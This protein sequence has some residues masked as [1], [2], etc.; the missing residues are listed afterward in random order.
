MGRD[1]RVTGTAWIGCGKLALSRENM[2]L[3][4]KESLST[5]KQVSTSS[6]F[7]PVHSFPNSTITRRCRLSSFFIYNHAHT[8]FPSEWKVVFILPVYFWFIFSFSL[9]IVPLWNRSEMPYISLCLASFR[10]SLI[11]STNRSRVFV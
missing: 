9:L 8:N 2:T 11:P 7:S 1:C 6:L 4:S 5:F 3:W 10:P